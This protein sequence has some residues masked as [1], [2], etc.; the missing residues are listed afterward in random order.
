MGLTNSKYAI[1]QFLEL[2]DTD[3][4]TLPTELPDFFIEQEKMVNFILNICVVLFLPL[5]I[6]V[7]Y[8]QFNKK[9]QEELEQEKRKSLKNV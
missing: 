6:Y 5:F 1:E 4:V 3:L 7:I 9:W 8:F 2:F